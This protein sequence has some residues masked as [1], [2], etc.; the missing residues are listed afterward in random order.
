MKRRTSNGYMQI[1]MQ[2]G[3]RF[4]TRERLLDLALGRC[5]PKGAMRKER[6]LKARVI[7]SKLM[8]EGRV[9]MVKRRCRVKGRN[10]EITSKCL[11]NGFVWELLR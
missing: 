3:G 5:L 2:K 8:K 7:K 9:R 11:K 4:G 6:C 1:V 10:Q